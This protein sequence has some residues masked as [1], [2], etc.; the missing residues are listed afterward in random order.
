MIL[1]DPQIEIAN[2]S[3]YLKGFNRIEVLVAL[4]NEVG[5]YI[6]EGI[7]VDYLSCY[8]TTVTEALES[9]RLGF[10]RTLAYNVEKDK[11]QHY[12]CKNPQSYLHY[13]DD[14]TSKHS[15]DL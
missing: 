7:N 14:G 3:E 12:I 2:I 10:L 4:D 13:F 9:F 5:H 8:G 6:V 1:S 11:L 15:I